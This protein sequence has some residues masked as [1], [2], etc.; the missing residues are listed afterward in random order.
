MGAPT[1]SE[2]LEIPAKR[3]RYGRWGSSENAKTTG[4]P[5][6][7]AFPKNGGLAP[8]VE[9]ANSREKTRPAMVLYPVNDPVSC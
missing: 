9:N 7:N 1:H 3:H 4:F 5:G 2:T 6:R 8:A